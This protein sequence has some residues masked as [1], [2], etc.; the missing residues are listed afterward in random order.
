MRTSDDP[1]GP[2]A[3]REAAGLLS[4]GAALDVLAYLVSAAR[5]QVEEAPEYAPMRLLTAARRLG[6]HLGAG[7]SPSTR[8]FLDVL[9]TMPLTATPTADRDG[10]LAALDAV[11][12]ALADCLRALPDGEL[13]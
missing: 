8:A 12:V 6:E 11:C 7:A 3:D 5:T 1:E 13:P 10:Y 9:S 4:E 2:G